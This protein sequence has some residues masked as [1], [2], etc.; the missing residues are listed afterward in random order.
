MVLVHQPGRITTHLGGDDVVGVGIEGV[1]GDIEVAGVV[2][3]LH[4]GPFGR[5]LPVHRFLL[6]E[7]V[8]HRRV[9]PRFIRED[10]VDLDWL[11]GAPGL[12][13]IT[14]SRR[15]DGRGPDSVGD[16]QFGMHMHLGG[17]GPRNGRDQRNNTHVNEAVG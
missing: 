5:G 1:N 2:E 8:D 4:L 13:L 7:R 10:P 17:R 12:D 14:A 9:A 6:R 16:R 11:S 15:G 3:D